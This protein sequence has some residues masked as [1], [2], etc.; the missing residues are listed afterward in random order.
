MSIFWHQPIPLRIIP[1][2]TSALH[3]N[4]NVRKI[5]VPFIADFSDNSHLMCYQSGFQC[6]LLGVLEGLFLSFATLRR[7]VPQRLPPPP[8]PHPSLP[9][10]LKG[11]SDPIYPRIFKFL[12]SIQHIWMLIH[13]HQRQSIICINSHSMLSNSNKIFN[14]VSM[15][16]VTAAWIID[17]YN[18]EICL[19]KPWISKGFLNL[20]SA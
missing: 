20:T 9:P 10:P 5:I 15:T 17:P 3:C 12:C 13:S 11:V 8:V 1:H 19:Y 14:S 4:K 6:D 18:A 2:H 7:G 16:Q